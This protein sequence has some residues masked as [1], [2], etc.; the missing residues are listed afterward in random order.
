MARHSDV[1]RGKFDGGRRKMPWLEVTTGRISLTMTR[2]G[3]LSGE[4]VSPQ[5]IA[6]HPYRLA[7]ADPFVAASSGL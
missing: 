4:A 1:Q 7:A 2:V 5:D 6:P 3:G